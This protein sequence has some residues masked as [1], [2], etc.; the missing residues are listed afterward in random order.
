MQSQKNEAMMRFVF[1]GRGDTQDRRN[2]CS[3]VSGGEHRVEYAF[4]A[5]GELLH[6]LSE[7]LY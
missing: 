1:R 7:E 5:Y 2:L 3:S 4:S 6:P